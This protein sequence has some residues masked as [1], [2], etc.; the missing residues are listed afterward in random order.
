MNDSII[1]MSTKEFLYIIKSQIIT[2]KVDLL[3]ILMKPDI[4]LNDVCSW[5]DHGGCLDQYYLCL[6]SKGQY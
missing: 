3:D 4:G 1:E 2:S 5:C 6:I